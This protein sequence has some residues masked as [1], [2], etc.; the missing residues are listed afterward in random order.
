MRSGF[1]DEKCLRPREE[2][3]VNQERPDMI[4]LGLTCAL[5]VLIFINEWRQAP[6]GYEDDQG[7][8]FTQRDA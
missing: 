8:H 6:E 2:A 5:T 4:I 3:P 1:A 7:F